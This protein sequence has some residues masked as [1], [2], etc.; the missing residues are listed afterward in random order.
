M[1]GN[2]NLDIEGY[3][4]HSGVYFQLAAE[5]HIDIEYLHMP[6]LCKD[7][8]DSDGQRVWTED[9]HL[10]KERGAGTHPQKPS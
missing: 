3:E 9:G 2:D 5:G 10:P 8:E 7:C 4:F 1:A 6:I